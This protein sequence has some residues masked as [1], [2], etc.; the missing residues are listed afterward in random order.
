MSNDSISNS[1]I[2]NLFK[3]GEYRTR[4]SFKAIVKFVMDE[5]YSG[6]YPLVG[7]VFDGVRW[8]ICT[9][10]ING[11]RYS[12]QQPNDWDLVPNKTWVYF[13]LTKSSIGTAYYEEP[14]ANY[15]K[16]ERL[17]NGD[18]DWSHATIVVRYF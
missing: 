9:W 15:I 8:R 14:T 10:D 7:E 18:Y 17:P 3:P 4:D 1:S 11:K 12:G 2:S 13:V 6:N 5:P 16:V